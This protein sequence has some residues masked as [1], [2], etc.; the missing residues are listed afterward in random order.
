MGYSRG[1][2]TTSEREHPARQCHQRAG[3]PGIRLTP[4]ELWH[5]RTCQILLPIAARQQKQDLER[6][7]RWLRHLPVSS[8]RHTTTAH[9]RTR[10]AHI[11]I[12]KI[13]CAAWT[14]EGR[15]ELVMRLPWHNIDT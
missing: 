8:H 5:I 15:R 4:E 9:K 14:G 12:D 13:H 1:Y 11:E 2:I 6:L 3:L 10:S 7:R